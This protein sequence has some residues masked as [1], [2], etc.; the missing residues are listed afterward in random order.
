MGYIFYIMNSKLDLKLIDINLITNNG[1][2][3]SFT[4]SL[5]HHPELLDPKIIPTYSIYPYFSKDVYYSYEK[6]KKI[7][8]QKIYNLFFKRDEF[9]KK[10]QFYSNEKYKGTKYPPVLNYFKQS[11]KSLIEKYKTEV[12]Y[13][14][15]TTMLKLLFP[16]VYPFTNNVSESYTLVKNEVTNYD[17][18]PL[19]KKFSYIKLNNKTYTV[20][21]VV[22][23]NDLLNNPTYQ[24]ERG[25]GEEVDNENKDDDSFLGLLNF[26]Y[27]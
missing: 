20:S 4:K 24:L 1:N 17:M 3:V 22:W 23:L 5:I 25:E 10:I 14:N 16:T 7:S 8:Y 2:K 26:V 13:E 12:A 6:M 21:N 27:D 11:D 9:K 19:K 18:S 15:I